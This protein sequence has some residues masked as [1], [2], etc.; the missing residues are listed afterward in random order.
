MTHPPRH[1]PTALRPAPR[2]H[3]GRAR[4]GFTLVEVLVALVIMAVMAAMGWQGV[5][6]MVRTRDATQEASDRTLRLSAL[7][8]QWEQDLQAVYDH[9]GVPG[10]AFDGRQL[11]LLRRGDGGVQIVVWSLQ[12]GHWQRWAGPAVTRSTELLRHLQVAAQLQGQEAMQMRLLDGVQ[13]WQ[14]YYWRQGGWT[15]AQSADDFST[16]TASGTTGTGSG[17][18]AGS[19]AGT[20]EG[21]TTTTT[22]GSSTGSTTGT[23]TATATARSS[24]RLL[25]EGVRLQ[26]D[27]P[28]GRLTRDVMLP[29]QRRS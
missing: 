14:L 24:R 5:A 15:N 16:A 3:A 13:G 20:T 22:S 28:E 9:P 7:I 17:T 18:T 25:P 10:L 19:G 2:R 4:A 8:S 27:L 23:T 26:L 6:T 11:R 1:R 12:D 21:G 29:P